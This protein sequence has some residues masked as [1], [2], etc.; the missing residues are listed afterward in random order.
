[1]NTVRNYQKELD[2]ILCQP[3]IYGKKLLLH[4]CCA[5]CSSY[6]LEYLR[7]YFDLTVFYYNPNI[8]EDAEYRKRVEEEKRLIMTLNATGLAEAGRSPDRAAAAGRSEIKIIEGSYDTARFYEISRGLEQC[9]EGGERCFRCYELRLGETARV[10]VE[11]HFDYFTTTLTIS[12][13]KNAAKLNEIGERLGEEYGVA[14]LPSDF[15]KRNGYKRSIELSREYHLYRQDYC[16]CVYSR[17]QRM[18]EKNS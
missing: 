7:E 9:P 14:F 2:K 13:L 15:K 10:A 11:Q 5:P 4:A 17:A 8:T 18:R 6:C 1:M 3:D 12:P 16:G